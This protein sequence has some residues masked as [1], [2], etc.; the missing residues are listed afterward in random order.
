MLRELTEKDFESF[1]RIAAQ[2]VELGQA[3]HG[4]RVEAVE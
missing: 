4:Y 1:R 2:Y 3:Y